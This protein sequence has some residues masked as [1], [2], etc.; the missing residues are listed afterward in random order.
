MLF[1]SFYPVYAGLSVNPERAEVVLKS[2]QSADL[3]YNVR[4]EFNVPIDVKIETKDWFVLPSNK[5]KGISVS[6]WLSVSTSAVHL[7]PGE[8][9]EVRYKVTVPKK[10]EGVLVGMISFISASPEANGINLAISVPVYV[11][12][13]G[14]E[15]KGWTID[16]P[17]F[18]LYNKKLQVSCPVKNDGNVHIR[19][20]GLI[21]IKS[22]D[23][24]VM[25]LNFNQGRPVYPGLNR[26]YAASANSEFKPGDYR[27]IVNISCGTETKVKEKQ[28]K[29]SESGEITTQ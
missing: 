24:T 2:R 29:I 11:T 26:I 15:K 23:K 6:K 16:E 18:S 14:T 28:I 5:E 13:A 7:G 1:C 19:P 8:S 10:A 3:S 27:V 4:N 21:E 17:K 20:A 22:G 12:V 9:R 25:I